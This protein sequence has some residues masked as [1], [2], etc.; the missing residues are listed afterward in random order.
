MQQTNAKAK[1]RKQRQQQ[2]QTRFA[3]GLEQ[4]LKATNAAKN[5]PKPKKTRK[6]KL[7][8]TVY[9]PAIN[10]AISDGSSWTQKTRAVNRLIVGA[11]DKFHASLLANLFDPS[12]P[13]PLPSPIAESFGSFPQNFGLNYAALGNT[14]GST[15]VGNSFWN[16][17]ALGTT[18]PQYTSAGA[19]LGRYTRFSGRGIATLETNTDSTGKLEV[20]FAHDPFNIEWPVIAFVPSTT[21]SFT[22]MNRLLSVPW[23]SNPYPFPKTY[24]SESGDNP[25]LDIEQENI[26][27]EGGSLLHVHTL[28]KNAY[29]T[30][31]YQTRTGNN[32]YD[33]F[34]DSLPNLWTTSDPGI[35]L[36][37]QDTPEEADG[38]VSMYTGT[39]WSKGVNF[40][41]ALSEANAQFS[42]SEYFRRCWASGAPFI[43]ALVRTTNAG[44]ATTGS[45]QFSINL[46]NWVA[47]A[48]SDP[49]VASAQPLET[50]PVPMPA[51]GRAMRTRGQIYKGKQSPVDAI[52]TRQL[53]RIAANVIPN[54]PM[55]RALVSNPT[56][57][58][59]SV[60]ASATQ[61]NSPKSS[62]S[63]L[64]TMGSVIS[65]VGGAANFLANIA[66]PISNLLP[67]PA[68]AVPLIEEVPE[69]LPLLLM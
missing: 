42:Y 3:S 54:T 1:Q 33:R 32:T 11:E 10:R 7:V 66:R 51:W 37:L 24:I 12:K 31:S 40:T 29:L 36:T 16:T 56:Q 6:R 20:W 2:Q 38:C 26:Y 23:T 49:A 9:N 45:V 18:L 60:L 41:T 14:L 62:K 57:V 52:W 55:T 50:I 8:K 65:R 61:D 39:T 34:V 58:A 44:G 30:V 63:W 64:D 53:S 68:A 67:S 15:P 69:A 59:P 35:P 48:P 13:Y 5:V 27:Y 46:L 21:G 22:G 4:Y 28:N 25:G 43:R 19:M 47:T 17:E